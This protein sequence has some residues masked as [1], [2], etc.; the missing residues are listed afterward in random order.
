MKK[1][2]ALAL[3]AAFMITPIAA[4]A[5]TKIGFSI[6]DLRV[7]R[8]IRDRDFFTEKA[9]ALGAEV[10]VQSANGSETTQIQQ[11]ENMITEGVKTIVIVP[12]NA[13][14]LSNVIAE[15]KEAGIKV[16]SYDRLILD[17]DL[18]L[19]IS[20]DNVKVGEMQAQGLVNVMPKGNY[21]LIGGSQLDNNASLFRKG[22]MNVLKP[23][24]DK[25][26]I[27]ILGDQ[28]AKDWLTEEALK[29]T[30]SAL[31]ANNNKIDAIVASN[32]NLAGGAIQA[33]AAQKLAGKTAVSGQDA[34]LTAIHR[35]KEG[36]QTMTVYKSL[37]LIAETAAQQAVNLAEGKAPTGVNDKIA[38]GKKE[39]PTISLEIMSVTKNNIDETV[40]KDGFYTKEQVYNK[41]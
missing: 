8:W 26:D 13:K 22:Q 32:D 34:D 1:I 2:L 36:T 40:I 9:K 6:D 29:I 24:V 16:I 5:K 10:I 20:F 28:W 18:D 15:A 41:K 19:Y 23:L 31:T 39:V 21:Y 35:I 12:F 27:K 38:N 4:N 25:G 3:A 33:L 7:E 17:A 11:I 37:K 14:G 30:E